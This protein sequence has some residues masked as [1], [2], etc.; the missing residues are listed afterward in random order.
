MSAQEEFLGAGSIARLGGVLERHA[1]GR[2]FLVTGH[3]SYEAS[4]A[5]AAIE[6]ILGA[7]PFVRFH[8]FERNP[9]LEDVRR[10]IR[11]FREESCGL[12]VAAGGG[13]VMDMAKAI[14]FLAAQ[15]EDIETCLRSPDGTRRRGAP[16][17]AIPTTSGSGSEATRFAVLYAD[18]RKESLEHDFVLPDHAIVD[19]DLTSRLS[20]RQTAISGLDAL[21]Q[22]VESLWSVHS[23]EESR[24][25]ADRA[26]RLALARLERAVR[27]PDAEARAGMAE[28]AHLAGKAICISKTTACHAVSYPMT[29]YFNVPHGLA[30]ALT[31]P[32]MLAFNA[33][34]SEADCQ[35]E[36]GVAW[37]G[38][39]MDR[40]VAILA[41]DSAAAAA[42]RLQDLVGRLG[43]PTR[44]GGVGIAAQDIPLLLEHGFNPGRVRNNPRRLTV[45]TLERMLT[46]LL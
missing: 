10:G 43:V 20:P 37:V 6:P 29:S 17:A 19:P 38:K 5:R 16:L 34:V 23:T 41:S 4:G 25:C 14:R 31:L 1:P 2:V 39:I 18:K 35:D 28:A 33:G 46:D 22:A 30:V 45:E 26:L 32:A 44:L 21:S 7:T 40:L 13:S 12:I 3:D 11:L 9:C 8:D 15:E 27:Q 24:A 36:R 42:G